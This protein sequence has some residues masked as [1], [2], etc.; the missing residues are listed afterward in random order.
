MPPDLQL[1][2]VLRRHGVPFVVVGGHA[3]NVHGYARATEDTDVVW[4]RSPEAEEALCR[5]LQEVD[6]GYIGKD[7][8]PVTGIERTYPVSLQWI[9]ATHLM[10]VWTKHGFV[11]LFDYIPG[12]PAEDVGQ[13][14]TSAHEASGFRFASLAWLRRMKQAAGRTKDLLDLENLPMPPEDEGYT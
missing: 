8:D 6:A 10:M 11:D 12:F 3:V 5:A 7:I 14:L 2:D 1:L 4:I 9:Q 13:L